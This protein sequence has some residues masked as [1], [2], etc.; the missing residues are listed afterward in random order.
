LYRCL[1]VFQTWLANDFVKER[2]RH[3]ANA[4]KVAKAVEAY[5]KT[6]DSKKQKKVKVGHGR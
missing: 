6:K 5:H 3:I 2:Q 4:K 1:D